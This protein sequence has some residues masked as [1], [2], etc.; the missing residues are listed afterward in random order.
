ML[1]AGV[2]V[3][4][5]RRYNP[6]LGFECYIHSPRHKFHR[7]GEQVIQQSHEDVGVISTN[8]AHVK[9]TQGTEEH[10]QQQGSGS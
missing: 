2:P 7:P 6:Y 10:L 3:P 4:H 1:R 8:L 5:D 9:V